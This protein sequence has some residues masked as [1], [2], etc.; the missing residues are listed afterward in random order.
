M[1]S[2]PRLEDLEEWACSRMIDDAVHE[3]R[4]QAASARYGDLK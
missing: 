3:G 1:T 2:N 4:I